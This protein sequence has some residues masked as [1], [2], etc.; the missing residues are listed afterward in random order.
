MITSAEGV[1]CCMN[2]EGKKTLEE[3]HSEIPRVNVL[4]GERRRFWGSPRQYI[5]AEMRSNSHQIHRLD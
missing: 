3:T 4:D 2:G 1:V 5:Y